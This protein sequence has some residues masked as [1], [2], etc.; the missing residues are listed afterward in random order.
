MKFP[1]PFAA[2]TTSASALALSA[3]F[4][5][6]SASAQQAVQWRVEDGG[7]GHWYA[8]VVTGSITWPNAK[9]ACELRGGH[10]AS[11]TSQT[12]DGFVSSIAASSAGWNQNFGPWLGGFQ[13]RT[14]T[15]YV[16]PGA[17]WRWVTGEAWSWTAWGTP[18]FNEPNDCWCN[19]GS[20]DFLHYKDGTVW[21]DVNDVETAGCVKPI[22]YLIEW[23]ADCNSDGIVDYGQILA[24]DLADANANNIPDCCEQSTPCDSCPADVTN[25]DVVD[26]TD[27]ASMLGQ[28]GTSGQG[29]FDADVNN[30]AFVDGSDLAILL[31]SWGACP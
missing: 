26:G 20:E 24:G 19:C 21:N 16:E 14:A 25:N 29:E 6:E 5:C 7:N 18:M 9:V 4:I 2:I 17:G 23:S 10:L 3:A 13:D 1:Q 28:W 12:E 30:D 27:L 11:V 22:A 15:D 8:D 31:G